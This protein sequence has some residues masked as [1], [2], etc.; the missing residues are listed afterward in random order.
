M[1]SAEDFGI[2]HGIREENQIA[3]RH[4][5]RRYRCAVDIA[6]RHFNMLV[7]Q[8][9]TADG[10]HIRLDDQMFLDTVKLGNLLRALQL[11]AVALMII[12]ADGINII[13]FA[14]GYGHA[15]AAVKA[16]RK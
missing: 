2:A 12:E 10:F 8:C 6:V 4:I 13:T 7:R 11:D 16:A 14:L 15:R 9:R 1:I 5:R 3:R